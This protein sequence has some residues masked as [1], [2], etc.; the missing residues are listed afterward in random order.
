MA[1]VNMPNGFRALKYAYERGS[2]I[3]Q[4]RKY[5]FAGSGILGVGDP[6][7]RATGSSSS[8]ANGLGPLIVRASTGSYLTGHIIGFD[9]VEPALTQVGYLNN[10]AG[11]VYVCDDPDVWFVVQEGGV[12][13]AL[14]VENIGQSINA[15]TAINANT[16]IGTSQYQID[17]NTVT[18]ASTGTY[19]IEELYQAANVATGQYAKWVVSVNLHTQ[20]SSGASS[21]LAI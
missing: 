5:W 17:N 3:G 20:R 11:Y 2:Y 10:T 1:N 9:P 7:V 15:I 18:T 19:I 4:G 12:G 6:V 13:T 8:D 21:I 16:T 14:T